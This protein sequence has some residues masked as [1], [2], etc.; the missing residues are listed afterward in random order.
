MLLAPMLKDEVLCAAMHN[1]GA[2]FTLNRLSCGC[3]L[4]LEL[5]RPL[6][7]SL[8]RGH[9]ALL[10]GHAHREHNAH[11]D[12]LSDALPDD[13][14]SQA[15]AGAKVTKSHR[16]ELHFAVLDVVTRECYMATMSFRDPFFEQNSS[17][18]AGGAKR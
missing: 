17:R 10:G 3:E 6:S 7:D 2:A 16:L 8:S 15:I 9:F 11:T 18:G 4:T 1:A 12:M 13:V 14:W 5:L